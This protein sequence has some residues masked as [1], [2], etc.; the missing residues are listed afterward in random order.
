MQAGATG[1]TVT[2]GDDSIAAMAAAASACNSD[3]ATQPLI[4]APTVD[5]CAT[6]TDY[7]YSSYASAV[8]T[9]SV[10]GKA[11]SCGKCTPL[12]STE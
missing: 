3:D 5:T 10:S 8:K 1:I 4:M 6:L 2:G 9:K 7:S 11:N 12:L